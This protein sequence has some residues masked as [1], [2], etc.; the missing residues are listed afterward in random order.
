MKTMTDIENQSDE[1][2][3]LAYAGGDA[4]AFDRLF[5]RHGQKIFNLFLRQTGNAELARD[6]AQETWVRLIDAR[7]RYQPS[8]SFS[9]WLYT[10][11]M[12]LLRDEIKRRKRHGIHES[13]ETMSNT[14]QE[15]E[16]YSTEKKKAITVGRIIWS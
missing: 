9:S 3:M 8:K 13:L 14:L 15:P 7:R 4:E 1:E 10:I 6:L 16:A 11:A 12:N 2:L 5:V